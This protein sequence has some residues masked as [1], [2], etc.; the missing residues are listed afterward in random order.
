MKNNL[1]GKLFYEKT[2]SSNDKA[3]AEKKLIAEVCN[4][5]FFPNDALGFT[6]IISGEGNFK[7]DFL[8]DF[9][10]LPP[11][12]CNLELVAKKIDNSFLILN[13]H[14]LPPEMTTKQILGD[15]L[16]NINT[17]IYFKYAVYLKNEKQVTK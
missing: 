4:I 3:I 16:K 7:I 17:K 11:C 8:Y 12:N 5:E 6:S 2:Y 1:I 15:F 9:T 13:I 14:L 10:S